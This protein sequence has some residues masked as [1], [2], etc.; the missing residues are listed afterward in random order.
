MGG[1]GLENCREVF[2]MDGVDEMR[3]KSIQKS[4]KSKTHESLYQPIECT[5]ANCSEEERV[6]TRGEDTPRSHVSTGSSSG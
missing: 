4:M 6:Q 5:Q 1:E 2:G 3:G